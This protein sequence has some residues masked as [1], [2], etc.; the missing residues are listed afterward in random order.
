VQERVACFA[1]EAKSKIWVGT[2]HAFG[3]EILRKYWIE[4]KLAAKPKLLDPVEALF[5]LER[6]LPDL[7]LE[8]YQNLSE[9]T[10][11]LKDILGAISR[12]K[13][14]LVTAAYCALA[15]KMRAEAK[16][17]E[18][19]E[20]AG[21]A[22]EVAGVYEFYQSHLER[23]Q[24]LDF[25]DLIFKAVSTLR[26]HKSVRAELRERF[27][28]ILVDE[29]QDVNRASGLLLKELAGDGQRLWAVGDARQAIYR[30]R[31]ASTANM[32]LFA[33][34]FPGA[35][36]LSLEVN[37]RS[38]PPILKTFSTLAPAMKAARTPGVP[39][40][41]RAHRAH[42]DGEVVFE[43]TES[44]EA[45]AAFLATEILKQS[46]RGIPFSQQAVICRSHSNLAHFARA[47]ERVGIPLLYLGDIF[48]RPEGRDLLSLIELSC[49]GR[50]R[51]LLRVGR[52][53][54]YQIPFKDIR[55]RPFPEQ[56]RWPPAHRRFPTQ[57]N[58]ASLCWLRILKTCAKA[59][60]P[61]SF[62]HSISS[63]EAITCEG[64]CGMRLSRARNAGWR[65]TSFYS[66]HTIS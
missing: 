31:G 43:I 34:D 56:S 61:G 24:L 51:A 25:G 30:W 54:E 17:P 44:R 39:E 16:T 19:V 50:G 46:E 10:R 3:L 38:Q 6:A 11:Y 47:L 18:E 13:D 8:H 12:A 1:P 26:E 40:Q 42:A 7:K 36:I 2:F 63:S 20:R 64:S 52:F 27:T 15:E 66:S 65:S 28:E 48:E 32:R 41:W 55:K 35:H 23:E 29:Y 21:K 60:P 5:L 57:A 33:S 53:P 59:V 58:V 14:E 37:Y 4:S 45:E 49:E 22:L 9:P 62:F